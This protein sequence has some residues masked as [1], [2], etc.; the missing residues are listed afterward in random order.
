MTNYILPNA[1][2]A[3]DLLRAHWQ[4]ARTP[5][6]EENFPPMKTKIP[7]L[8]SVAFF[9]LSA[10]AN[11]LRNTPDRTPSFPEYWETLAY[12][13][14]FIDGYHIG[15]KYNNLPE[16]DC[17]AYEIGFIDGHKEYKVDQR[18]HAYGDPFDSE[19][20]E[21]NEQIVAKF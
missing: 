3:Q 2:L 19:M 12:E 18:K 21:A 5:D 7:L 13:Q 4:I 15:I 16:P 17:F 20:P 9:L 11:A 14:G 1:G 10:Q 6:H 8:V